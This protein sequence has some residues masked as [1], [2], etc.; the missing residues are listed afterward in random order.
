MMDTSCLKNLAAKTEAAAVSVDT[1][2]DGLQD[3]LAFDLL[4]ETSL[5]L[6]QL[7]KRY[8]LRSD[9]LNALNESLAKTTAAIE[10]LMADGHPRDPNPEVTR[11][12]I[13]L[14][15]DEDR[16]EAE[17][18]ARSRERLLKL[19]SLIGGAFPV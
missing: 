1:V 13:G 2:Q 6:L 3:Y 5:E 12:L 10:D 11:Q 18:R 8:S 9:L 7:A 15:D 17:T 14:I 4:P 16:E 19:R